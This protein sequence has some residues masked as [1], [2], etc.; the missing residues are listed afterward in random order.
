ML[1]EEIKQIKSDPK[2]L[3]SFG[4]VVGSVFG[5]LGLFWLWKGHAGGSFLLWLSAGLILPALIFPKILKPFQFL[6]MC[7]ALVLGTIMTTVILSLVYFLVV[8][9]TGFLM[10]VTGKEAL[11]KKFP[12]P[13]STYWIPKDDNRTKESYTKQY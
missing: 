11:D 4:L 10:R 12:D 1:K 13:Q 7:L 2:T 3:R 9:P 8:T 5:V 6:W